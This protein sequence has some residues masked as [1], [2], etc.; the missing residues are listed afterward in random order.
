MKRT[1]AVVLFSG[2]L[3]STTALCWA[4]KRG[5]D[6][7]AV[8]F[9]Y[10]QRH[11]RENK[12]ARKIARLLK[13]PLY[14]INLSFPWL[15]ASSLVDVRQKLPDIRPSKIGRRG[16]IPSTYVPGRNLVFA[17]IGVSLADSIGASSVVLGPNIVDYSGYPDCRPEFYRALEK[18]ANAGTRSGVAGGKIKFITPLINLGKSEIVKFA[19]KLGVP[20]GLTWSCYSGGRKPCGHCDSCKLRAKG[21][22]GAGFKD[23]AFD[24]NGKLR[25]ATESQRK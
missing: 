14:E 15:K 6:C 11:R 4:I 7:R 24:S 18:A 25:K 13:V 8:S 16:K 3:D 20:L 22:A 12:S 2:G 23:P 19:L 9:N 17:S 10:G 1:K 5:Y 21:F